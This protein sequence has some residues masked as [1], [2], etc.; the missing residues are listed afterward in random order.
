MMKMSASRRRRI[1]A[2]KPLLDEEAARM[3]TSEYIAEDPVQFMY[4]YEKKPDRE[5]GG[6]LAALMAWGRRDIVIAKTGD[7]LARMGVSPSAFV[8][9]YTPRDIR[10]F[11]GFRHRTFI[12]RDLHGIVSALKKAME[13]R[14]DF[15]SYW[16]ESY[17]QCEREPTRLMETFRSRFLAETVDMAPRTLRHLPDAARGSAMKRLWMYLRWCLRQGSA[18]DPGIWSFMPA[19]ELRIPLDVHVA[20]QSRRLGLL[21]RKSNDAMAVEELTATLRLLDP[22]DPVRY[23]YALLG[24]GL[25]GGVERKSGGD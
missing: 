14:Q 16:R 23:D 17:E 12:D 6:F 15:E 1:L 22:D 18:A 20:R 7:L 10:H 5:V 9:E 3:E 25:A 4:A 8:M 11:E 19:S 21:R 2:L 13:G 24:I